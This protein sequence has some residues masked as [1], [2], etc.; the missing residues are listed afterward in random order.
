V[1]VHEERDVLVR[2]HE[3]S[4]RLR[5]DDVQ[6]EIGFRPGIIRSCR[7]SSVFSSTSRRPQRPTRSRAVQTEHLP[8]REL[9]ARLDRSAACRCGFS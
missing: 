1:A 9:P 2:R 4:D 7:I 6:R 5:T 8:S 3:A